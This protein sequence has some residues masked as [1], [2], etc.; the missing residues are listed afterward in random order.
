M[1]HMTHLIIILETN[2]TQIII[3][4]VNLNIMINVSFFFGL[5]F[6][7]VPSKLPWVGNKMFG[8]LRYMC[9]YYLLYGVSTCHMW[10]LAYMYL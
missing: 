9:L 7:I 1:A 10:Y 3:Q 8:C 4:G 5:K 2:S 6:I